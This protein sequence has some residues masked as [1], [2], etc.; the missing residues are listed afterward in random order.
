LLVSDAYIY[1]INF[2]LNLHKEVVVVQS[3]T[4]LHDCQ[5]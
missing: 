1:L 4:R 5:R 2:F 3:A